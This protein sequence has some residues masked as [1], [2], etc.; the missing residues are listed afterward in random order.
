ME[1]W[2][3]RI[4]VNT[5]LSFIKKNKSFNHIALDVITDE[6]DLSMSADMEE[7]PYSILL[8]TLDTLDARKRMVFS[9]FVFESYSH[10]EISEE[11][12]ITI[13]NSRSELTRARIG[14]RKT[15]TNHLQKVQC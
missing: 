8:S 9:L 13:A 10:K 1:G 2:I 12:N 7:I 5:A 14:L 3:R 4:V 15:L 11:L 6:P